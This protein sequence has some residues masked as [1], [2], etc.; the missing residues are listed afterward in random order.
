MSGIVAFAV[1]RGLREGG[2]GVTLYGA[3][4]KHDKG[5]ITAATDVKEVAALAKAI[6]AYPMP[7]T[8]G[9]L[10]LAMLTAASW[11]LGLCTVG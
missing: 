3:V 8:R 4:P 2:R 6:D 10:K 11:H 1:R 9:A 5:H 7:I